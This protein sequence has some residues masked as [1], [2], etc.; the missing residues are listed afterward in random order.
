[1]DIKSMANGIIQIIK[2]S[3]SEFIE[4]ESIDIIQLM[5]IC[6]LYKG[7]GNKSVE[8][9]DITFSSPN[10]VNEK[11]NNKTNENILNT[12]EFKKKYAF[13]VRIIYSCLKMNIDI[14]T[15]INGVAVL[16]NNYNIIKSLCSK[17]KELLTQQINLSKHLIKNI[18][19]PVSDD[20]EETITDITMKI[21]IID[22]ITGSINKLISTN[23]FANTD[24]L[25]TLIIK[26]FYVY[27]QF[28]EEYN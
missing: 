16:K 25:F 9:N 17:K 22:K 8:L 14:F 27:T 5:N 12:E 11:L 1:M 26:Y 3:Y 18:D 19:K 10:F 21:K 23:V 15:V 2:D 13:F 24:N 20:Y 4:N 6:D 7:S 28:I